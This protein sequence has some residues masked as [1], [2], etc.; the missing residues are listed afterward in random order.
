MK[1]VCVRAGCNWVSVQ[2]PMAQMRRWTISRFTITTDGRDQGRIFG[3]PVLILAAP[4]SLSPHPV[5]KPRRQLQGPLLREIQFGLVLP[6]ATS[7]LRAPTPFSTQNTGEFLNNSPSLERFGQRR[8]HR[9]Q[10]M[11]LFR[12]FAE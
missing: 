1:P 4:S 7:H 3:L 11:D 6:D 12:A 5:S 9:Y 2:D 10:E 8:I